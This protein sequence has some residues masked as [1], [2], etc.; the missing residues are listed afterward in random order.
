M[1]NPVKITKL[2]PRLFKMQIEIK[3]NKPKV[4]VKARP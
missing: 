3:V 1:Q 4:I 2:P